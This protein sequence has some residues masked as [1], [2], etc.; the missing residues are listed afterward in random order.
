MYRKRRGKRKHKNTLL[1]VVFVLF[2]F[3]V[4]AAFFRVIYVYKKLLFEIVT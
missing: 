2:C 1:L 3:F 4:I